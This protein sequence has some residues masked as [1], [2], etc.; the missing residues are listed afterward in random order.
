MKQVYVDF[1]KDVTISLYPFLM[2]T[3]DNLR[4]FD[5]DSPCML[6]QQGACVIANNAQDVYVPWN[7]CMDENRWD[8]SYCNQKVGITDSSVN[9]CVQNDR[10]LIQKALDNMRGVQ[11]APTIHIEGRAVDASYD[12]IKQALCRADSSLPGCGGPGP[13]PGPAPP[14]PSPPGPSPSPCDRCQWNSDCPEGQDCYYMSR[15]ATHG[16]C[17]AGPPSMREVVV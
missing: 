8:L 1:G 15:S 12:A 3:V 17:S 2:G 16:C 5:E 13:S 10:A 6:E 11:H 7:I 14:P 9:D 4:C